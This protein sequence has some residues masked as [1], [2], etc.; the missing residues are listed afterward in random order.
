MQKGQETASSKEGSL[1]H[2][3]INFIIHK[4]NFA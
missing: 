2:H 1:A 4:Q 3:K